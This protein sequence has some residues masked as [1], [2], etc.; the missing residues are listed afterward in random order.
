MEPIVGE[1]F[2]DAQTQC[3]IESL[4]A[5][6][7]GDAGFAYSASDRAVHVQF[8]RNAGA[9]WTRYR[10]PVAKGALQ[11]EIA[12]LGPQRFAVFV[13][14]RSPG[15]EVAP[16]LKVW[17]H[18]RVSTLNLARPFDV[19]KITK[20][21]VDTGPL[22]P[23]QGIAAVPGGVVVAFTEAGNGY[24]SPGDEAVYWAHVRIG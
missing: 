10:L 16:L 21:G 2:T 12:V 18:G 24:A 5:D 9:S 15:G 23:M 8:S 19:T 14:D 4:A 7:A 20:G 3:C 13:Y 11:P 1:H 6:R 17:D 22:G